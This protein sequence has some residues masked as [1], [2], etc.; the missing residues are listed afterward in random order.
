MVV[1]IERKTSKRQR[2]PNGKKK[3]M[4]NLMANDTPIEP[5]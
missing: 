3:R 1:E 2:Q 5:I 4:N